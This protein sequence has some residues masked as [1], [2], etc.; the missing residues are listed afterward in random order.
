MDWFI[1]HKL[2]RLAQRANPERAFVRALEKNLR[3][4][5]GH[6]GWWLHWG[7]IAV[8][9][10]SVVTMAASATTAYAYESDDVLPDHPLYALRQGVEDFEI[11]VAKDPVAKAEVQVKHLE[12]RMK[13]VGLLQKRQRPNVEK[14]LEEFE[15][16]LDQALG[17]S[18]KL[19]DEDARQRISNKIDKLQRTHIT[20]LTEQRDNAKSDVEKNALDA[21]ILLERKKLREERHERKLELNQERKQERQEEQAKQEEAKPLR[22]RVRRAIIQKH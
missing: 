15:L 20:D 4:Q 14:R 22:H 19:P 17:D 10:L 9:G 13:E 21:R 1:A 7:R 12:R 3:L 18:D 16:H 8:S 11:H 5:S 6:Q 2:H